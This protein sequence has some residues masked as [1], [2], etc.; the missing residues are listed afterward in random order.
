MSVPG[1]PVVVAE[2]PGGGPA[3]VVTDHDLA[4]AVLVD[5]RIGKDPALAPPSWDRWTS[6]L[7][8]TAAEQPSLTTLDGPAHAALRRAHAPL[9][10][11]RRAAA[12]APRIREIARGLLADAAREPVVDLAADFTTR[13]PLTVLCELLGVPLDEI[14]RAAEACRGVLAGDPAATGRAMATYGELAA[15]ALAPGRTGL[16][17]ELRDTVPDGTSTGTLHYLIF[18]LLFAGQLTTDPA[19]GFLLADALDGGRREVPADDLVRDVLRR[20]PPAPLSLWRFTTEEVELAGTTL[21]AGSPVLV[22]IAGI[23]A[24]VT[25][26]ADLSFGAGPHFCTGAHLA[27]TELRVL[28][29][30]LR[31]GYPDARLAVPH[32]A[33]R[34]ERPAGLGGARL[35]ALPVRLVP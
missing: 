31:E 22:D 8:P 1:G 30:V 13:Y 3:Y 9:L 24:T 26:G 14:D 33:L 23:G 11:A 20:H 29:E 28:V 18:T 12:F 35:T 4:R 21:P 19:A 2:A 25:D 16:A 27:Q 10:S 17:A 5:P 15:S 32:S 6:G 7:E 34:Q